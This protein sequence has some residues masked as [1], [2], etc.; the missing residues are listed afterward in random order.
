MID[1][2]QNEDIDH[3]RNDIAKNKKEI[4]DIKRGR[5]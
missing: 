3:N 2:A 4:E 1:K 5:K